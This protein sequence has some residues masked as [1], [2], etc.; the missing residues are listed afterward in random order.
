MTPQFSSCL[1]SNG[2]TT[3]HAL[4]EK[5]D[6]NQTGEM[7]ESSHSL[8]ISN[9]INEKDP[10]GRN[11]PTLR[12]W[13]A[14]LTKETGL[15]IFGS[16]TAIMCIYCQKTVLFEAMGTHGTSCANILK[17]TSNRKCRKCCFESPEGANCA[18][19]L[20]CGIKKSETLTFT[21]PNCQ[22][23]FP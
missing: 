17:L 14:E 4:Q 20:I 18:H 5:K 9:T 15:K 22:T 7:D 10:L 6:Q 13:A 21:C 23:C 11:H 1:S 12:Q 16:K 8:E 3:M 2:S 19:E